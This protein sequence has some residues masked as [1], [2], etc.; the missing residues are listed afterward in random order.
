MSKVA[1]VTGAARRV[2]RAIA[3]ELARAGYDIGLH[4]NTSGRDAD[5]SAAA[6]RDA[7]RRVALLQAD[8]AGPAAAA[9]L[10]GRCADELG[11]LD[12]LVNNASTF[13]PMRLADV[14]VAKWNQTLAVNLTAPVLLCRAAAPLISAGGA[15]VNITDIHAERPLPTYLAYCVSKAGLVAL[16]RALAAELA[17]NIRVNA[18]A[19]GVAD[20]PADYS[21][22]KRKRIVAR[23]PAARA[24]SPEE[25]AAAVRFLAVDAAYVTGV[26]LAV[27]GGRS[28]AW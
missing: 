9:T 4:F 8:L 22:A 13:D 21:E 25:V 16:T 15:I 10:P 5:K 23:I 28:I 6:I 17:P 2:G 3:L 19:P 24:G 27:D 7:G 18:V 1:L 20:W 12:V 26:V 14:D 11:R